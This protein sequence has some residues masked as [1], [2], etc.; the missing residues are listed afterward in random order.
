MAEPRREGVIDVKQNGNAHNSLEEFFE[1]T[2]PYYNEIQGF[3]FKA[4]LFGI[5]ISVFPIY[6]YKNDIM[7]KSFNINE[8]NKFL[9]GVRVLNNEKIENFVKNVKLYDTLFKILPLEYTLVS[10]KSAVDEQFSS[11]LEKDRLD[12][13][14]ILSH[15][16]ELGLTDEKIKEI[17]SKYPDYSISIVYRVNDSGT[18]STMDGDSYKELVLTNRNI[19]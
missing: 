1:K 6:Q 13:E 3:G 9:L 5:N 10:K 7:A 8:R 15:E 12:I 18:T 11:R 19:S 16:E 4:K 2:K 14:Y 17:L